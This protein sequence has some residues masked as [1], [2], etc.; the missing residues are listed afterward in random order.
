[1]RCTASE[2]GVWSCTDGAGA[3][4]AVTAGLSPT[5]GETPFKP[6]PNGDLRWALTN[7]TDTTA[8]YIASATAAAAGLDT[9][10]AG[11]HTLACAYHTLASLT[12]ERMLFGYGAYNTDGVYVDGSNGV[13]GA[14]CIWNWAGDG[15]VRQVAA[16]GPGPWGV[17]TCRKDGTTYSARS[18]GTTQSGANTGTVVAPTARNMYFGR[19]GSAGYA[20]QG[21]LAWCQLWSRA[22]TDAEVAHV[23]QL[24]F[25]IGHEDVAGLAANQDLNSFTRATVARAQV[26]NTLYT[27]GSGAPRVMPDGYM[28][29]PSAT[30]SLL[31][32]RDLSQA[33]W[34]KTNAT[35]VLT[36]TGVDGAANSASVCTASAA[37]ATIL[38]GITA[39]GARSTSVYLRR[40]TGMGNVAVTRDNGA[41][42]TDVSSSV[43]YG[44]WFRVTPETHA[45]LTGSTTNPTVGIRISTNGDAFDVDFVQDE[46]GNRATS[47]IPTTTATVTKNADSATV[48]TTGWPTSA[49]SVSFDFTP[50]AAVSD[51]GRR[52]ISTRN[53]NDGFEVVWDTDESLAFFTGGGWTSSAALSWV[54]GQR[55]H[56]R[57]T[58]TG[59]TVTLYRDGTQLAQQTGQTMPTVNTSTA[60]LGTDATTALNGRMSGFCI[61]NDTAGC[62]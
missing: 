4:I 8:P 23:E 24:F 39:S 32:S 55:Y 11:N 22:L 7:I 61:S 54:V 41:S 58:W 18:N 3:A 20:N 34:T 51:A 15:V 1:M 50:L 48:S 6:A 10:W 21:S 56:I 52:F 19:Y 26:G 27:Y 40:N 14:G 28:A 33:A 29:E 60:Y 9:V 16:A 42:W 31:Q 5:S 46:S 30:N 12:D 59:G 43:S 57:A 35:C 36:A 53:G 17:L 38:Q 13:N 25:G 37:N 47:P 2:G 49:G 62:R 44:T 45:A